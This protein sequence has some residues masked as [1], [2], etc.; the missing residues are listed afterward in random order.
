MVIVAIPSFSR[1]F[2]KGS[3]LEPKQLLEKPKT[4]DEK[5]FDF[6]LKDENK[7]L[8]NEN[9]MLLDKLVD[10]E[11]IINACERAITV[12]NLFLAELEISKN[13]EREVFIIYR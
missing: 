3:K 9:K 12:Y 10:V 6:N 11:R 5:I 2:K 7:I 1:R 13:V 8:R 4:I